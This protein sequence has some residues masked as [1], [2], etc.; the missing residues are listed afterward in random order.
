ME[1]AKLCFLYLPIVLVP[2]F[3]VRK[4]HVMLFQL[5]ICV[6][7]FETNILKA[8]THFTFTA[9]PELVFSHT[10]TI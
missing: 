4:S 8:Q 9:L 6:V 2:R 10:S 1:Y 3:F 7:I 5:C